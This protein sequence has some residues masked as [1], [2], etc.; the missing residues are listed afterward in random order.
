MDNTRAMGR[1]QPIGDV[2]RNLQRLIEQERTFFQPMLQRLSFEIFHDE[3]GR[4][5]LLA[6]VIE[7]ANMRMRE[8]RDGASLTVEPLTKLGIGSKGIAEDF[9]RDGA[10]QARVAVF[11]HFSHATGTDGGL[12]LVWAET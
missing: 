11:V 4:P 9:D 10:I 1:A 12:N 8:L 7:G 5:G 3:I 6:D 2:N